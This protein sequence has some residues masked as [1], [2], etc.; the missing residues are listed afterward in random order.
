M[1][2]DS[3]TIKFFAWCNEGTSDKIWGFVEF[4]N[5]SEDCRTEYEKRHPYWY[6]PE[7][8]SVYNFWGARGKC[9]KFKRHFGTYQYDELKRL[10]RKK[11][12]PSG[13]KA[14]YKE[15]A[16]KDIESIYPGFSEAFEDQLLAAKWSSAV[17]NDDTENHSFI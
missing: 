1:A 6:P 14:P 5:A 16:I 13:D 3:Y 15:I 7:P 8:G 11:T 4:K 2:L 12:H 9:L 10:A 17:K